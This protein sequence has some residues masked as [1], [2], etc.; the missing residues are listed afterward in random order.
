[1]LTVLAAS[2]PA[3][4]QYRSES[5]PTHDNV[6][7]T[8]PATPVQ[9]GETLIARAHHWS[10]WLS[11]GRLV[12]IEDDGGGFNSAII[13]NSDTIDFGITSQQWRV[14][15]GARYDMTIAIDG[16]TF[17]GTAYGINDTTIQMRDINNRF[18]QS[19]YWGLNANIR[20]NNYDLLLSLTGSKAIIDAGL[21]YLRD[22][23]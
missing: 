18:L 21:R 9:G 11:G 19:L 3:L 10:A 15:P 1:M 13:V 5:A 7:R 8:D 16:Q 22:G 12:L 17:S 6:A 23:R 4:G 20:V 2:G 14:T